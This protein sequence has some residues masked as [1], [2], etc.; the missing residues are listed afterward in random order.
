MNQSP[1]WELSQPGFA[2][3]A[4]SRCVAGF[5]N[6]S[7]RSTGS[8]HLLSPFGLFVHGR[9]DLKLAIENMLGRVDGDPPTQFAVK[10]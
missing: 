2:V 6:A 5:F 1:A 3:S 8:R 4:A 9:R 7:P 10:V